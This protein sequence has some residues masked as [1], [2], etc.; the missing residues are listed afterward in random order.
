MADGEEPIAEELLCDE[1]GRRRA[2]IANSQVSRSGA[3]VEHGIGPDHLKGNARMGLAPGWQARNQPST[4]ECIRGGDTQR[5]PFVAAYGGKGD[6]E[7]LQAVAN[8]RKQPFARSGERHGT[9][10]AAE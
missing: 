6:C 10:T 9:R 7:F 1:I 5:T 2:R 4:R 8:D 3:E